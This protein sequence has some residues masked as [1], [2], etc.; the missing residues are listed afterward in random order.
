MRRAGGESRATAEVHVVFAGEVIAEGLSDGVKQLGRSGREI[1]LGYQTEIHS[2]RLCV[3]R[4][5]R[6]S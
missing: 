1:E 6:W 2:T 3:T 5:G 4:L